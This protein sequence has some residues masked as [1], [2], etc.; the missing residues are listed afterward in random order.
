MNIEPEDDGYKTL[1]QLNQV[2]NGGVQQSVIDTWIRD[3]QKIPGN[4]DQEDFELTMLQHKVASHKETFGRRDRDQVIRGPNLLITGPTSAGKTL[5][6][7]M[8]IANHLARAAHPIGCIYAVPLRALATEK[9]ERFQSIFGATQVYVSS[10]DYQQYDLL[11]LNRRF[12]I[13]VVVYEKLYSWLTHSETAGRILRKTALFIFD[14]LQM[15]SDPQRGA[16]LELILTFIRD[17]QKKLRASEDPHYHSFRIVGLGPSEQALYEVAKW[18]DATL[19]SVP[20]EL[21]PVPLVQGYISLDGKIHNEPIPSALQAVYPDGKLPMVRVAGNTREELTENFIVRALTNSTGRLLS[22]GEGRRILVYCATKSGAEIMAQNLSRTLGKRQ[23]LDKKTRREI[24]NLEG[25][26]TL[27]ILKETIESGVG[28]HHGDLTLEER[29]LVEDLFKDRRGGSRLD[30]VVC[31]PTLAMG[32]NLPADY[33]LFST[34]DT[35]R[36]TEY[37][38]TGVVAEPLTPL[39]YKSF[40]GRAGRYRPHPQ[41]DYHGISLFLTDKKEEEAQKEIVEGLIKHKIDP[42]EPALHRWPYG[43]VPLALGVLAWVGSYFKPDLSPERIRG[44]FADTFAGYSRVFTQLKDERLSIQDAAVAELEGLSKT[45][46]ELVSKAPKLPL[47]LEGPGKVVAEHGIHV[48]TYEILQKLAEGLPDIL[49][50]PFVLLEE[51]V[52]AA[53]VVRLYPTSIPEGYEATRLTIKLRL[54]FNDMAAQGYKLGPIANGFLTTKHVPGDLKLTYLIRVVAA[55]LWMQGEKTEIITKCPML[56][57][58]RRGAV[59]TLTDQLSWFMGALDPLWTALGYQP[60]NESVPEEIE[61]EWE[62]RFKQIQWD[63]KR[64]ELRLRYGVHAGLESVARLRVRGWHRGRLVDLWQQLGGWEHPVDLLNHAVREVES[65]LQ[66]FFPELKTSI[67][68]R[69]WSDD[70]RSVLDRQVSLVLQGQDNYRMLVGAGWEQII[71]GLYLQKGPDLIQLVHQALMIKPLQIHTTLERPKG[72]AS[73]DI[74]LILPGP[75]YFGIVVIDPSGAELQW[76]D[77]DLVS[78]KIDPD[79]KPLD[80]LICISEENIGN[81]EQKHKEH[82]KSILMLTRE[83]FAQLCAR[84]VDDPDI[85]D[86]GDKDEVRTPAIHLVKLLLEDAHNKVFTTAEAVDKEL[87]QDG[88][89][90]RIIGPQVELIGGRYVNKR[91]SNQVRQ[92]V[93]M[94]RHQLD[95]I[96][97]DD[98]YEELDKYS[99]DGKQIV[100]WFQE[101]RELLPDQ[102]IMCV[103][104]CKVILE[105][106]LQN[107]YQWK[108][109]GKVP[110]N[111]NELIVRLEASGTLPNWIVTQTNF[112]RYID[113]HSLPNL[114]EVEIDGKRMPIPSDLTAEEAV[115]ILDNV[116]R[117]GRWYLNWWREVELSLLMGLEDSERERLNNVLFE[118]FDQ[119]SLEQMLRHKLDINL[120]AIAARSDNLPTIIF[121]LIDRAQTE[122]WVLQLVAAARKSNPGN[123]ALLAFCQQFVSPILSM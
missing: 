115:A 79:G 17:R 103:A 27:R 50:H 39:E 52:Q 86:T 38:S 118:A 6:A 61:D 123:V 71:K 105:A 89:E 19:I 8:L 35:F 68:K 104:R 33:M 108:E 85:G 36:Q 21:R 40:A 49:D 110:D 88:N 95:M 81:I 119:D 84:A 53:E 109:L 14:E 25:T 56:P 20:E 102:P 62:S 43:L 75:R 99:Q 107:V 70:P 47:S 28:F 96:D 44:I 57:D 66:P 55:W 93:N 13:A 31:T 92:P 23:E 12:R 45:H 1:R 83:A 5:T 113:N 117:V 101:A 67:R 73:P 48:E 51:L 63:I 10:S 30:V 69:V 74:T 29:N 11:I 7:E 37:Q 16:K 32:V 72:A 34:T 112:G 2:P 121:K 3:F 120:F 64:C 60:T 98:I 65:D 80:H 58:I 76:N 122:D 94:L 54:F 59:V 78:W 106:L 77:I 24:S 82:I 87:N 90:P 18:L 100:G 114:M 26:D 4:E 9:W 41:P 15:L 97:I 116:V 42:I 91:L 22:V 111:W 46:H